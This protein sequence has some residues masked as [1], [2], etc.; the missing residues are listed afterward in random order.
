VWF[1]DFV[2]SDPS[3]PIVKSSEEEL[4]VVKERWEAVKLEG[5]VES[6][7]IYATLLSKDILP[8]GHLP[9]RPVVLPIEP[10]T[11][12]YRVLDTETLRKMGYNY[13]ANWLEEAEKHWKAHATERAKEQL[14]SILNRFNYYNKLTPQNPSTRFVV[15]YNAGGRNIVSCV[16]DKQ[17]LGKFPIEIVPRGFIVD[18]TL[19]FYETNDENEAHYLSAVLNSNVINQAIKS[20]QDER[21]I[22]K[23]PFM[24]PI[25]R[26]NPNNPIHLELAKLNKIS[27]DKV[28]NIMLTSRNIVMLR[29]EVREALKN[30]ISK[31]DELVSKILPNTVILASPIET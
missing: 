18:Y 31:I 10:V 15:I 12:G 5:P 6:N 17:S 29:K 2:S 22:N 3:R 30:E 4:K 24:L 19:F 14:K 21:H 11:N 13:M 7:F 28:S 20:Y 27:H 9:F 16:V 25:P 23:R 26:Y 8:F 1:I